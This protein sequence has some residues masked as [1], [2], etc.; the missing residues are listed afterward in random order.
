MLSNTNHA[1]WVAKYRCTKS[2]K[3]KVIINFENRYN[4]CLRWALRAALFPVKGGEKVARTSSYP[5]KD[6]LNFTGIGFPTPVT[7]ITKLEKQNPKL[8][9]NVFAWEKGG[10]IVHRRSAKEGRLPRIN[11]MLIQNHHTFVKRLIAP[12]YHQSKNINSK[13]FCERCLHG[14]KTAKLLE[15]HKP[16]CMGQLKK[17][18]RTEFLKH[19]KNKVNF[20]NQ[21]KQM[22]TPLLVYPD[23]Q[24]LIT[25]F[26]GCA[27]EGRETIKTEVHEPC[28]FS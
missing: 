22:K 27:K 19:S 17:P 20:K 3:T 10:V 24:S 23:F 12:L 25:K 13:H 1:E 16:K 28:G 15:R 21:H 4:Q 2:Y 18:T 9:L 7:Q 6:G 14:Y 8:A 26:Q 11:L 5:T